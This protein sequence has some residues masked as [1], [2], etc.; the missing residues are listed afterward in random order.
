MNNEICNTCKEALLEKEEIIKQLEHDLKVK[1]RTI[2]YLE[3][4]LAS[5]PSKVL[6]S[7]I[8]VFEAFDKDYAFTTEQVMLILEELQ[9]HEY[10]FDATKDLI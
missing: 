2:E 10:T 9:Y 5:A 6:M 3:G 8:K 1:E 4:I 7:A